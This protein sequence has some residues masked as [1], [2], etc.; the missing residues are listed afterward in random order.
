MKKEDLLSAIGGIDE[1]LLAEAEGKTGG[2]GILRYVILVAAILCVLAVTVAAT[3]IFSRPITGCEIVPDETVFPFRMDAEGN[4]LMEGQSGLKV[5]MEVEVNP[6]APQWLEALY[7]LEPGARWQYA[8]GGS[9]GS[10]YYLSTV[11]TA[12]KQDGKP[13]ELRLCQSVV[14]HYINNTYGENCVDTLEKL[15]EEDGVTAKTMIIGGYEVLYVTIPALPDYTGTDYCKG[16]ETRLY[17]T[18]GDYMLH[19]DYPYWV[20][21]AQAE[22]MLKALTVK[23]FA[24]PVPEDYGTVNPQSIAQRLPDLSLGRENGTTAANNTM[25]LGYSAYADGCIYLAGTENSIFR[26]DLASGSLEELILADP[27]TLPGHLM[28]TDQYVL[29]TNTWSDLY[30]LK[31]DGTTEKPVFQGVGSAQLYAEGSTL[32]SS[33]GILDLQ[34]GKRQNWPEGVQSWY[35]DENYI[36]ATKEDENLFLRAP[37]G[38]MDFEEIG[39]DF[40]PI[41]ILAQGEDI[42]MAEGGNAKSWT[43]I[44]YRD[45]ETQRLPVN[46]V[47]YQVMG[48]KVIYRDESSNGNVLK[49]YDL[50]TGMTETLC[51]GMFTFSILENR[52]ICVFC[53]QGQRAWY[54]LIDTWQ[55]TTTRIELEN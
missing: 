32:Y 9:S 18:D 40:Y 44:R 20:T 34:T 28:V 39:L 33:D 49:S 36:Y 50:T 26:Y 48:D 42:Y 19:L 4:I 16:G 47:E 45:G 27:H 24:A 22:A 14:D 5:A 30:A 41:K 3:G 13:G 17:W 55:A 25:G 2:R 43:V 38:T 7:V 11:E 23:A 29:Y 51:E 52:Y 15:G 31:K 53:A 37:K 21:D 35:V 12:W 8:G 10:Q 46:A 1:A 6:D 54:T